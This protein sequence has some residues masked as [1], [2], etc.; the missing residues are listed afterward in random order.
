M[1]VPSIDITQNLCQQRHAYID[2][3]GGV[4]R[5]TYNPKNQITDVHL[6]NGTTKTVEY[7]DLGR[8]YK[9]TWKNF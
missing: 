4:T 6:P 7:D 5:I 9:Q 2:A 3:E 8:L 1:S